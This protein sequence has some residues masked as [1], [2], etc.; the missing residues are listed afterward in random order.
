[1]AQK[2]STP[3]AVNILAIDPGKSGGLVWGDGT[4]TNTQ[5]SAMPDTPHDIW[6]AIEGIHAKQPLDAVFM[7][8]VGG[9]V[10]GAGS[11]GSAM[12]E[13]GRNFGRLEG[14]VAALGVRLVMIRPARWQ[15]AVSAGTRGDRTKAEWKR[16]LKGI[17]QNL[18][19]AHKITLDTSDA[20]LLYY[21]AHK[22]L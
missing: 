14:V 12:F 22:H 8:E 17:A 13:F 10:G 15:K 1:M 19:P 2:L 9:Y 3:E 21:A 16:H 7:E 11:P 5:A 20:F 6:S 4:P 18:F